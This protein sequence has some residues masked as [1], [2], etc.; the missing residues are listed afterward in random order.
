VYAPS[1][2]AASVKATRRPEASRRRFILP[3]PRPNIW[4]AW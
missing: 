1:A 2:A 4:N 3:R